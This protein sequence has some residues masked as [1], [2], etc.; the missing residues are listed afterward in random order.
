MNKWERK[1]QRKKKRKFIADEKRKAAEAS[2]EKPKT[3]KPKWRK[4]NDGGVA[5]GNKF[6]IGRGGL[7]GFVIAALVIGYMILALSSA[8]VD[9]TGEDMCANPYC[10]WIDIIFGSG[11]NMLIPWAEA[12][13]ESEPECYTKLC[14]KNLDNR[15]LDPKKKLDIN[16]D[17]VNSKIITAKLDIKKLEIEIR[18]KEAEIPQLM[19]D[20]ANKQ[21]QDL[22]QHEKKI[23]DLK[24]ELREKNI[25]IRYANDSILTFDDIDRVNELQK[26]Y[27]KL[28]KEWESEIDAMEKTQKEVDEITDEIKEIR[29]WVKGAEVDLELMIDDLNIMKKALNTVYRNNNF[30]T[31]SLSQV[32]MTLIETGNN[33]KSDGTNK[34]P[35]YEQL[36]EKFD[37]TLPLISGGWRDNA[38]GTDI[39]RIPSNYQ[40][41]WKFYESVPNWKIIT[42]DPDREMYFRAMSVEIQASY[43]TSPIGSGTDKSESIDQTGDESVITINDGIMIYEDCR[44][45]IVA[46]DFEKITQ[47]LGHFISNCEP[48]P[49]WQSTISIPFQNMVDRLLDHIPQSEKYSRW[50]ESTLESLKVN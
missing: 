25:E 24:A 28:Q 7:I 3:P 8:E 13:S 45:A 9:D 2:G 35:T 6:K 22:Y 21:E 12:R 37:N 23:R 34:C 36:R 11:G 1:I 50:L 15:E 41:Y 44:R 48:E 49:T 26:E 19:Y 46:P 47:A 33:T 29:E 32:C 39:E 31:I 40:N 27:V 4:L 43:F 17:Q 10:E 5:Y 18:E 42:V 20:R 38:T 16:T 14:Q 30:V